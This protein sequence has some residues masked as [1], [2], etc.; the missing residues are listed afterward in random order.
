MLIFKSEYR[1]GRAP[2]LSVRSELDA[3]TIKRRAGQHAVMRVI[4]GQITA[5]S[6]LLPN[7]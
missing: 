5:L 4:F 3:V 1:I 7:W 2:F 6:R